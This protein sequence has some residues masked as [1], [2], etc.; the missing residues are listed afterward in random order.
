MGPGKGKKC[1]CTCTCRHCAVPTEEVCRKKEKSEWIDFLQGQILHVPLHAPNMNKHL[2]WDD[3]ELTLSAAGPVFSKCRLVVVFRT[4][5]KQLEC[6]PIYT[7][8]GKGVQSKSYEDPEEW[9]SVKDERSSRKDTSQSL[10]VSL[11][12]GQVVRENAHVH[13]TESITVERAGDVQVRGM[14][15]GSSFAKLH[16]RRA[17]L[18]KAARNEA[19]KEECQQR[20]K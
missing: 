2:S 19:F 16:Q 5:H 17:K 18:D 3:H 4:F 1:A 6:L 15:E 7:H 10:L 13:V 11:Y 8:G 20:V 12:N 9:L 14:M